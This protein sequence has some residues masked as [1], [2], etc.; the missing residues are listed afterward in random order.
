MRAIQ[1]Q[2]QGYIVNS[3]LCL[4][5]LCRQPQVQAKKWSGQGPP[6]VD[7]FS[8]GLIVNCHTAALAFQNN[9]D[10]IVEQLV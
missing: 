9:P 3:H 5:N 7:R 1:S 2:H 6:Q 10:R 8:I 4:R